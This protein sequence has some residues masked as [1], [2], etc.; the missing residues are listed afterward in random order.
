MMGWWWRT[1]RQGI[2]MD[3]LWLVRQRVGKKYWST[4]V[5]PQRPNCKQARHLRAPSLLPAA[6]RGA[7]EFQVAPPR[8]PRDH[9]AVV[10]SGR[11]GAE[12]RSRKRGSISGRIFAPM[13]M[14]SC[15]VCWRMSG[16]VGSKMT[17][18]KKTKRI[19]QARNRDASGS[20]KRSETPS[21]M[22]IV[23]CR[24]E[25]AKKR[26]K[27][28][29]TTM[30]DCSQPPPLLSPDSLTIL[31]TRSLLTSH[32]L[33]IKR[34]SLS[35]LTS[36]SQTLSPCLVLPSHSSSYSDIILLNPS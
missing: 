27:M 31:T 26:K 9:R 4:L 25:D 10:A 33:L 7:A 32:S 36:L 13:M 2:S 35:L 22:R 20:E 15:L 1:E 17:R 23:R 29:M 5:L 24:R 16:S 8:A 14:R 28:M 21:S 3:E 19:A 12:S 11:R 6:L 34:L 18:W 30:I